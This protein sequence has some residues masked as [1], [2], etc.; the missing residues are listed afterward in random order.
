MNISNSLSLKYLL[1]NF[2]VCQGRR[3]L[4]KQFVFIWDEKFIIKGPYNSVTYRKIINRSKMMTHWNMK[5]FI[6]PLQV[7]NMIE[8][9]PGVLTKSIENDGYF[10]WYPNI[11]I[12]KNEYIIY[13][14]SWQP[15]LKYCLLINSNILTLA[16]ILKNNEFWFKD[17]ILE[18]LYTLIG[19]KI[20]GVGDTGLHNII[21][22]PEEKKFILLIM[23]KIKKKF[24]Y[25][26]IFI[27][28]RHYLKLI[29]ISG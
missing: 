4:Y 23:I 3:G 21:T 10:I 8:Y 20:L 18:I 17:Q 16:T 1:E 9:I 2:I 15:N 24:H 7:S 29:E 19:L 22:N 13:E 25:V 12:N 26:K 14:E 6:I 11:G 27:F 5:N 28:R